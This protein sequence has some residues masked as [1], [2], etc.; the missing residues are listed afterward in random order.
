[1]EKNCPVC[2]IKFDNQG[3]FRKDFN[4]PFL[5]RACALLADK[6]D[7]EAEIREEKEYT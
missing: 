4:Y 6:I 7:Y 1:M 5:C 3:K 2:G